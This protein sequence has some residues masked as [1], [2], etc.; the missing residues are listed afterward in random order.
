MPSD[1]GSEINGKPGS[2]LFGMLL[3][4]TVIVLL[5]QLTKSLAVSALDYAV[6][7]TV[8]PGFD[9]LLVHNPG[10]AFSFLSQAGGWQRWILAG[11]AAGASVFITVWL[12]RLPKTQLLLGLALACILG[13]ALGNL[14]DRV[15]LGYV[16]DFISVYRGEWRFAT[17]NVADVSLNVGAALMVL[18]I[19]R[20]KPS[21]E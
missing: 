1:N 14:Y 6:P 13:G 20:G 3:L 4:A 15:A 19:V 12:T 7:H 16:I 18:D 2:R 17:F 11:I 5:D 8:F 10:A 21:H 9:F